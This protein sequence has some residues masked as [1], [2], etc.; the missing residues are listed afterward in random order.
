MPGHVA[1]MPGKQDRLDPGEVL[2]ERRTADA[3]VLGDLRHGHGTQAVPGNER[4]G[5][6]EDRV[7]YLA[8]MGLDGL[9]PELRN[10]ARIRHALHIDS[11][12]CMETR[13]LDLESGNEVRIVTDPPSTAKTV[14]SSDSTPARGP[15]AAYPGTPR[16]VKTSAVGV[17]VLLVVL[18]LIMALAGGEHGPGRHIPSTSGS[19]PLIAVSGT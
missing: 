8:A 17:I 1:F 18:V 14:A 6:I 13:C 7:T 9:I 11:V 2:V 12:Y 3:G 19:L 15:A 5:R 4:R 10:Q 16:W